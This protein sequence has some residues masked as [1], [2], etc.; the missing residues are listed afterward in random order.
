MSSL[1]HYGL[2]LAAGMLA[3]L[4]LPPLGILLGLFALSLPF[5]ASAH[6]AQDKTSPHQTAFRQAIIL[7]WLTGT[8]WFLFSLSW[9]S[10]ALI[11][12][13]GFHLALIPFSFLGLPLFFSACSGLRLSA[14]RISF[15]LKQDLTISFI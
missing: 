3:S 9:I 1:R 5:V 6:L 10:N 15:R 13:G 2:P 8:G 4:A 11:T 7:G 14:L 12:S